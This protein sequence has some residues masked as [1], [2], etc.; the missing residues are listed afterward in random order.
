VKGVREIRDTSPGVLK[1]LIRNGPGAFGCS[2]KHRDYEHSAG[3]PKSQRPR[4]GPRLH[5]M[6]Q[7]S[8]SAKRCG[9]RNRLSIRATVI[10]IVVRVKVMNWESYQHKAAA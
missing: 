2:H 8:A 5:Q 9:E 3:A 1:S 6:M 7:K 4:K 10:L